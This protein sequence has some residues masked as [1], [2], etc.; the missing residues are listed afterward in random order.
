M[1]QK[2]GPVKEPA[3]QVLKTIRRAT[4]RTLNWQPTRHQK[5]D[6][7][8]ANHP[9][10]APACIAGDLIGKHPHQVEGGN[11]GKNLGD[12]ES[13]NHNA[14]VRL[15]LINDLVRAR[16]EAFCSALE[17]RCEKMTICRWFGFKETCIK[18]YLISR[19]E[20]PNSCFE[21]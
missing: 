6:R 15:R 7:D 11:P 18:A 12:A 4:R 20:A 19:I 2:S 13:R 5:T 21:V 3:T 14:P 8:P 16:H 10:I 1:R 9:I 17:W